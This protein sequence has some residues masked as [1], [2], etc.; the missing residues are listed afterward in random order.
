MILNWILKKQDWKI[1][2][3]ISSSEKGQVA[4]FVNAVMNLQLP[5][6]EG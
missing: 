6:Y 3:D 5:K 1:W 4:G 2:T